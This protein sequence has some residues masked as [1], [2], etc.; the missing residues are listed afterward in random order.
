MI[1][2]RALYQLES[3]SIDFVQAYSQADAKVDIFLEIPLGMR[4]PSNK[5]YVLKLLKNLYGLKDGGRTWWEHLDKGLSKR[6]FAPSPSDPSVYLKDGCVILTYVDDILIFSKSKQTIDDLY[7]S[8]E[9]DFS[10]TDK[11]D[12]D[13]YLGVKFSK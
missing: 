7:K 12:I 9:K 1:T 10:V 11:G 13:K 4:D 5:G 2:L 3:R 6:G 8:L